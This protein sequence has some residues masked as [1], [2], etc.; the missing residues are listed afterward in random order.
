MQS[1]SVF[2]LLFKNILFLSQKIYIANPQNIYNTFSIEGAGGSGKEWTRDQRTADKFSSIKQKASSVVFFYRFV[3]LFIQIDVIA[4]LYSSWTNL[5]IDVGQAMFTFM[6][7][8]SEW[9]SHVAVLMH[10]HKD[11][12]HNRIHSVGVVINLVLWTFHWHYMQGVF[13]LLPS[14]AHEG[15]MLLKILVLFPKII[16]EVDMLAT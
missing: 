10:G 7:Q 1:I 13:S 2:C 14:V 5:L 11:V 15:E 12:Q 8:L 9:Y 4:A 3:L 16:N 6:W